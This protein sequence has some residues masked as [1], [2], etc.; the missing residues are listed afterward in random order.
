MFHFCGEEY[1]PH[2]TG[3][4]VISVKIIDITIEKPWK[5]EVWGKGTSTGSQLSQHILKIAESNQDFTSSII[6]IHTECS[7][8]RNTNVSWIDLLFWV[9]SPSLPFPQLGGSPSGHL[10]PSLV[11]VYQHQLLQRMKNRSQKGREAVTLCL[12]LQLIQGVFLFGGTREIISSDDKYRLLKRLF[13]I[14]FWFHCSYSRYLQT[15]R[16]FREEVISQFWQN[17]HNLSWLR[18]SGSDDDDIDK[19]L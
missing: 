13:R 4:E 12:Y 5:T 11:S 10:S 15:Q 2:T 8:K 17:I 14:T 1:D 16:Y 9:L 19:C 3:G 7:Q 6:C 18:R